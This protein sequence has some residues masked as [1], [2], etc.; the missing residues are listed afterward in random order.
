M[1]HIRTSDGVQLYYEE[2]GAGAPLILLHG[3]GPGVYG[4][5][6][7]AGNLPVF[8]EHFRCFVIDMPTS[9]VSG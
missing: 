2:T 8:A 9:T 7:F 4:W 1:P 3:S 5:A 6:N